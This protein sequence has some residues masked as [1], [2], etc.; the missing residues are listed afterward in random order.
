MSE[1]KVRYD[2]YVQHNIEASLEFCILDTSQ[3]VIKQ[4]HP[5]W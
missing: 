5:T 3:M 2:I 4:F 1:H